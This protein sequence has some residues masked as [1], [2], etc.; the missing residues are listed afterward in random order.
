MIMQMRR[1]V[2]ALLLALIACNAPTAIP[3]VTEIP[4]GAVD[5]AWSDAGAVRVAHEYYSGLRQSR[6][7]VISNDAD[8]RAI[9]SSL[10]ANYGTPPSAPAIDF[11]RYEVIVAAL[12]ERNS[13]GYDITISRI[14]MTNDY[15]YVE[16]TALRPGPR[17]GTTA[18]LTQPVDMV[19]IPRSHP[20]VI[21]V[22][23]PLVNDC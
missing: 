16:L 1:L 2:P 8:W 12:G 19:R 23:K 20:P 22:E 6:A 10:T 4:A 13:G 3:H 11:D 15:L 21:F 14:A 7:T 5:V 9:W 17:C 18:A